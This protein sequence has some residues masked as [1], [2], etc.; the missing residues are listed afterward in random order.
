[1]K[2]KKNLK[3]NKGITLIAL[4][5]TIIVLLILA[6]V[7]ISA[8]NEG[9][10]FAHAN[11]AVTKYNSAATEENSFVANYLTEM[12][13]YDG[14]TKKIIGK[15]YHSALIG[16]D[17]FAITITPTTITGGE[18]DYDDINNVSYTLNGNNLTI[19]YELYDEDEYYDEEDTY[20]INEDGL[21]F[22]I[23]GED[24]YLIY[25]KSDATNVSYSLLDGMKFQR[26][27]ETRECSNHVCTDEED[28]ECSYVCYKGITYIGSQPY[29]INYDD[30]NIISLTEPNNS[31]HPL[32]L[33]T[34]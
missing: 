16:N 1:M 15:Y 28:G 30:G 11:N 2:M 3:E 8:V 9:N 33:V 10:I 31:E 20:Y 24:S 23:D 5:I 19:S 32:L 14:E 34:E 22:S 17:E 27:S 13:K 6:V 7:T 26:E 29:I 21:M 4:I 18:F 12:G 25:I